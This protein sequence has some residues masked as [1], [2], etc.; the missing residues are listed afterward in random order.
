MSD[1]LTTDLDEIPTLISG[2]PNRPLAGLTVLVVEDSRF[3]S[4]AVR[5]LCL[6]SGARIRRAD[7]IRAALRHLQTYRPGAVIVDMGLPDGNGADMIRTILRAT[8]R[9]PVV[10]GISGD[11]D[12]RDAAMAAGADGFLTKPIESLATFQQAILAA[13]PPQDRPQGLRLLPDDVITPD[14]DALRDDLAHVAEVLSG[15]DDIAAIEYIARFLAGVARS[16]HDR[17]LEDAATALTRD[18]ANGPALAMELAR[19]S[20]MVQDRLSAVQGS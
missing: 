8:P 9:V 1:D 7:T 18:Q 6:R 16:S 17:P 10:L 19:I 2:L 12:N 5:L 4:E 14:Q 20:G 11:P 13:L 15:A 3:A